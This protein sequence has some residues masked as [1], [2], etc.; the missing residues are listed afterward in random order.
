MFQQNNLYKAEPFSITDKFV[1]WVAV[2]M[3]SP[4]EPQGTRTYAFTMDVDN[5]SDP[6]LHGAWDGDAPGLHD[7]R[8]QRPTRVISEYLLQEVPEFRRLS[9]LRKKVSTNWIP[10]GYSELI[11]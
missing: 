3:S 2:Q 11:S 1:F 7:C 6:M 8:A 10:P 9:E 5:K 4:T